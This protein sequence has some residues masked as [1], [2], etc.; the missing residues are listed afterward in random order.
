[1]QHQLEEGKKVDQ[2]KIHQLVSAKEKAENEEK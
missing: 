1:M 2:E